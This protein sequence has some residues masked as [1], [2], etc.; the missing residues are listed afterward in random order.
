MVKHPSPASVR[1]ACDSAA[2]FVRV[3]WAA[4]MVAMSYVA[5]V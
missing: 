4:Y 2:A 3:L 1:T 5:I